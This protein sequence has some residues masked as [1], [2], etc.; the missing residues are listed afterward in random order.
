MARGARGGFS[1][2]FLLDLQTAADIFCSRASAAALSKK[3]QPEEEKEVRPDV[4]DEKKGVCIHSER[5]RGQKKKK[6]NA[7]AHKILHAQHRN[8][9]FDFQSTTPSFDVFRKPG[10]WRGHRL[11]LRPTQ[12][13]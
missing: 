6:K 2:P 7:R 11:G 10:R 9:V 1:N 4:D 13:R 3:G 5:T 8:A 12:T